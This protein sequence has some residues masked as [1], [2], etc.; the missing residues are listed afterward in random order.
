MGRPTTSDRMETPGGDGRAPDEGGAGRRAPPASGGAESPTRSRTMYSTVQRPTGTQAHALPN[1]T[2]A[3]SLTGQAARWADHVLETSGAGTGPGL[4]P[5]YVTRKALGAV[6]FSLRHGLRDLAVPT[7]LVGVKAHQHAVE[8]LALYDQ[9]PVLARPRLVVTASPDRMPLSVHSVRSDGSLQ[10]VGRIQPK[11][12]AWLA[13]LLGGPLGDRE[14]PGAT[15]H[16]HAV[17]GLDRRA[18][19]LPVTLGVNVR[20]SGLGAGLDRLA[21]AGGARRVPPPVPTMGRA[22]MAAEPPVAY[23]TGGR[24][25]S[26]SQDLAPVVAVRLWRDADGTARM[27]AIGDG[28]ASCP[29][30]VRH[31]P[32]GP[33][34]GY[35]GSGPADCARSILL[36]LT[37]EATADTHYQAFKDEVVAR[38]PEA[39]TVIS[40]V[41]VLAWLAGR[42]GGIGHPPV[43]RAA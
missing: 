6:A 27:T 7:K 18:R 30:V 8:A 11:H 36:A 37:D 34:W 39:G 2:A 3:Q 5:S 24:A 29:H 23:R 19:G 9:L 38:V 16:L 26:A 12:V 1:D 21:G 14:C 42:A 4:P 17:T 35:G 32:S 41:A 13:P 33:E 22:E 15:V 10:P 28:E 25:D 31:S 43:S 40:R 20:V